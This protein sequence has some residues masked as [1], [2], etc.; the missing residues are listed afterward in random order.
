MK[1]SYKYFKA[2]L[3]FVATLLLLPACSMLMPPPPLVTAASQGH[4]DQVRNLLSR[5]SDIE[6]S[7]AKGA[8]PLFVAVCN[9]RTDI[10]K[11]LVDAGAN[12]NA[13]VRKPYECNKKHLAP[14]VTPLMAALANGNE[15]IALLL[16]KHGA[17]VTAVD[18]N[19]AGPLV[20][21]AL[22]GTPKTIRAIIRHKANINARVKKGFEYEKEPIFEG[23]TPLMC[24]LQL[25]RIKNAKTLIDLGADVKIKC[26]NGIDAVLIAAYKG[27][28][29][30]VRLLL[31]KGADTKSALTR[32]LMVGKRAVF[33]GDNALMA[34]ADAGDAESIAALVKAGAP[35]NDGDENNVTPLMVAS[36]KGNLSAVKML[37]SLGADVNART[38]NT[39]H[40]GQDLIPEGT[41]VLSF[42]ALGGHPKTIRFLLEQG[43]KVN[44][45]DNLFEM[46]PLFLAAYNN[47]Y[48]AV[49][50]LIEH[51]AD[52][53]AVSK[54]GTALNAARHWRNEEMAKLIEDARK[55]ARSESKQ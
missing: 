30:M 16:L 54:M 55:K 12:V 48:W 18:E 44:V 19:R 52:V 6:A 49:K 8:T 13:G 20:Y 29:E 45:K 34:A 53:F 10:A 31:A 7:D 37:V 24:A 2:V 9:N 1:S 23:F 11:Q 43:A 50:I 21:A 42:A 4:A 33:K 22:S 38:I 26:K 46:D 27:E 41:P 3:F 40:I 35:V 14:G 28:S 39:F 47:H 5:G 51:G 17:E 36:I 15:D 25:K 32:D